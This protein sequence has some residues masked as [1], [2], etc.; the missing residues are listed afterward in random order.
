MTEDEKRRQKADLL[1]ECQEAEQDLRHLEERA[2]SVSER[3]TQI[4]GWLEETARGINDGHVQI[5]EDNILAD[6]NF[7]LAMNMDT[8]TLIVEQIKTARLRERNLQQ[9]KNALG[10]K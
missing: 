4:A 3:L 6:G 9:R 7:R 5:R 8:V 1:L 10:L 2:I